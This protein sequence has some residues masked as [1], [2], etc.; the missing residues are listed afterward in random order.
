MCVYDVCSTHLTAGNGSCVSQC[1]G[2]ALLFPYNPPKSGCHNRNWRG[3]GVRGMRMEFICLDIGVASCQIPFEHVG[4]QW[5]STPPFVFAG[6]KTIT[7]PSRRLGPKSRSGGLNHR[8]E[9]ACCWRMWWAVESSGMLFRGLCLRSPSKKR[10]QGFTFTTRTGLYIK[11]SY[12]YFFTLLLTIFYY[13]QEREQTA[14]QP[15]LN[16]AWLVGLGGDSRI[17]VSRNEG[18]R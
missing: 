15:V 13:A 18:P 14:E 7:V 4:E 11:A 2:S 6:K 10:T 17:I 8:F 1:K 5:P 12:V 16:G 9:C 3:K